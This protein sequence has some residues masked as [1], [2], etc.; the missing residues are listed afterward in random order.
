MYVADDAKVQHPRS[1][2][3]GLASSGCNEDEIEVYLRFREEEN[4]EKDGGEFQKG[5]I[6]PVIP[7]AVWY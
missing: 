1:V 2:F 5:M 3:K 4:N 6:E 7:T